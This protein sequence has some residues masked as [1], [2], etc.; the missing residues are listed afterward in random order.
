MVAEGLAGRAGG[1]WSPVTTKAAPPQ[2]LSLPVIENVTST[3][4]TVVLTRPL[5]PNG[6]I[7]LYKILLNGTEVSSSPDLTQT[8]G[9][10]EP[11]KPYSLYQ[12]SAH[13][14]TPGGCGVSGA[15]LV[16]TLP[17]PPTLPA[18]PSVQALTPRTLNVSWAP[19]ASLHGPLARFVT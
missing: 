16:T 10:V 15:V 9:L 11:L 13:A 2:G 6:L 4:I 12:L 8:V 18:A 19:P 5:H 3:T 17:A 7:R 14:C 1:G